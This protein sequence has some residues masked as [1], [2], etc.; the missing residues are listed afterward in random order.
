MKKL[1]TLFLTL[2]LIATNVY[3]EWKKYSKG[4]DGHVHF[5]DES[6]VKRNGDKVK[7]WMYINYSLDN[8]KAKSLN[9]GSTR[10]LDEIDCVNDSRKSLSLQTFT[11]PNLEGDMTDYTKSNPTTI[12]IVPDSPY[13]TLMKLVCKK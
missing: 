7:V 4:E 2:F 13:A 1:F 6:T 9:V 12:Y 8:K 5:Y 3:A 10:S 11:K